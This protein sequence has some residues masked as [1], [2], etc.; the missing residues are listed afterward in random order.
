MPNSYSTI[1]N[2]QLRSEEVQ[3]IITTPPSWLIRWGITLVFIITCS[4]ILLSFLIRYPD[5]ISAKVMVTTL[6]P[7]ERVMARTSGQ[8]EKVLVTNGEIVVAGQRLAGF[9]STAKLESVLFLKEV[10][11]SVP[12]GRANGFEFPI[13][14]MT[15][16]ELGEIEL[17]YVD[18][19]RSYAENKLLLTLQP[20][21]GQLEGQRLSLLEVHERLK[22]Q[23]AQKELLERKVALVQIDF[24]RNK[25]LY[26][27][28]V[29]AAIDFEGKEM[30]YLQIQEQ[31][32]NM[33]V[34]ISQLQEALV[35]ADQTFRST[36]ISKEQEETRALISLVQSYH[37]LKRAVREWEQ[38]YVL[39]SSTGGI[40]SFQG[41][42]AAN[43]FV[44]AGE[45]VFSVFPENRVDLV[46]KLMIPSQNAGR[47]E[48]GQRVL[49]KLDNFP[50]QQFG[51]LGGI[52]KSVSIS[53][54][55]EG[56]YVV[57]TSLP[58]G[59]QSSYG[60]KI[61]LNQELLGTAEIIT[62]DLSVAERLFFKFKS[63]LEY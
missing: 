33:A 2:I 6:E 18:F 12:F 11:D 39:S 35:N 31:V 17:A 20:F 9:K 43:Q 58:Q 21:L 42:W 30:V 8:I 29:I 60:K 14:L 52:V 5:F 41:V 34:S 63:I 1:D 45:H 25:T 47:I 32:N 57:Y 56:N 54:D 16:L 26:E 10:L 37:G 38:Q 51:T 22:S 50:F 36:R 59:T 49:I 55:E 61:T 44:N 62:E 7:T 40:V 24:D 4:V 53:P 15:S 28:G 48:I 27:E 13:D 3:E 46:G 19:E 23:H